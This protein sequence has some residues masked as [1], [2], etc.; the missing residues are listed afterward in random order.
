MTKIFTTRILPI[1]GVF[2][3]T[4][5]L[6]VVGAYVV[7]PLSSGLPGGDD[8]RFFTDPKRALTP[9]VLD[10]H[11][12]PTIIRALLLFVVTLLGIIAN[13]FWTAPSVTGHVRLIGSWRP[14]LIAPV[15]FYPVY[16][17]ASDQPDTIVAG[18]FA[19]QNGFFWQ[20]VLEHRVKGAI[21]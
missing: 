14:L 16:L 21:E 13:I 4:F 19:F 9:S 10:V 15:V 1:A 17:M 20:T 18:C 5:A 2:A 6:Q 8:G 11:L 7:W 12:A 3:L